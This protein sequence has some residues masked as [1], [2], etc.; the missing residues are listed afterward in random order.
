MRVLRLFSICLSGRRPRGV[1][2]V[3]WTALGPKFGGQDGVRPTVDQVVDYLRSRSGAVRDAAERYIRFA[4]PQVDTP[5]RRRI[6]AKLGWT[7]KNS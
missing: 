1:D 6:E 2:A 3:V 5:Y 7:A 4:Q